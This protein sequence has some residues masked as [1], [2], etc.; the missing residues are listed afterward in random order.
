[1]YAGPA[2]RKASL[3]A[4]QNG[5]QS[6]YQLPGNLDQNTVRTCLILSSTCQQGLPGWYVSPTRIVKSSVTMYIW[7]M[8]GAS[9]ASALARMDLG[10]PTACALARTQQWESNADVSVSGQAT[11][12]ASGSFPWKEALM[13]PINQDK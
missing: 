9:R 3:G 4:P 10:Q 7:E 1:M 8:T 5:D 12:Q 6:T 13:W 2:A 11:G